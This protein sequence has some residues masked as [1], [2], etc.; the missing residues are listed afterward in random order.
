[1]GRRSRGVKISAQTCDIAGSS[2]IIWWPDRL[3]PFPLEVVEERHQLISQTS[4]VN[5]DLWH[6]EACDGRRILVH[7][8]LLEH[9]GDRRHAALDRCDDLCLRPRE[10]FRLVI[11]NSQLPDFLDQL[12]I[13]QLRA[14]A[15]PDRL[16]DIGQLVELR[17]ALDARRFDADQRFV[18]CP[19]IVPEQFAQRV[20]RIIGTMVPLLCLLAHTLGAILNALRVQGLA[21]GR[22]RFELR[23]DLPQGRRGLFP[24][25][26]HSFSKLFLRLS[27]LRMALWR[28]LAFLA[29]HTKPPQRRV[30]CLWEKPKRFLP[31]GVGI[32]AYQQDVR[33][34]R[35]ST[36]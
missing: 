19:P 3:G 17:L 29:P 15:L 34:D 28:R 4:A 23:L 20:Y 16:L 6:V 36:R 8:A 5:P 12:L 35:K 11:R 24:N 31:D 9:R 32:G 25:G 33:T 30:T 2:S 13:L 27:D 10:S 14:A 21:L 26:P 22:R 7:Q 1:M 18:E